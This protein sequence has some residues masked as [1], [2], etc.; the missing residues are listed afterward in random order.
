MTFRQRLLVDY[1]P[2]K[3]ATPA[4]LGPV[5][6]TR[7]KQ[8][9][10][11]ADLTMKDTHLLYYIFLFLWQNPSFTGKPCIE[12]F[13]IRNGLY[14]SDVCNPQSLRVASRG[15]VVSLHGR[16]RVPSAGSKR[17]PTFTHTVYSTVADYGGHKRRTRPTSTSDTTLYVNVDVPMSTFGPP[18]VRSSRR[19]QKLHHLENYT[20]P[21]ETLESS[22]VDTPAYD[23]AYF[24]KVDHLKQ[25]IST[26]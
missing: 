10:T 4:T 25:W 12:S 16:T 17:R 5:R 14:I 21:P 19:R 1:W 2:Q 15:D 22:R 23:W 20:M 9:H 18:T 24:D 8:V 26:L 13:R 11:R 7:R 3:K 6:N